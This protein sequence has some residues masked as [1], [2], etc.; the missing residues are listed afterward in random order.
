MEFKARH[1][2]LENEE[3]AKSVIV[4]LDEG[5]DFATLA[6]GR[7]TGPSKSVGGDLGWFE[8]DQMV[9]EF[10]EATAQLTD[11]SYS[12]TPVQTRFGWHVILREE[13]R[14][15]PPPDF[16]TVKPELEKQIQQRK[17]AEVIGG[18]REKTRIEVEEPDQ[19]TPGQ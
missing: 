16:E 18:I 9:S 11:G 4:E 2:L 14:E 13:S 7:S 1:I 6:S 12:K 19:P 8:P 3:D 15:L 10:S 17:I 5:A